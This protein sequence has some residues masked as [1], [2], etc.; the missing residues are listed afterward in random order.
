MLNAIGL[1]NIGVEAFCRDKLPTLRER[2]VTV[3]ANIFATSVDDFVQLTRRLDQEPGIAAV[4]LNVS[5]RM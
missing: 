5:V 2:N 4:E 1:A 3:I